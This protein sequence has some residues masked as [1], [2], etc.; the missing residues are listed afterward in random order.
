MVVELYPGEPDATT[1]L[2]FAVPDVGTILEKVKLMG[3]PVV[4]EARQTEWGTR[5]V[6]RDPDG[7]K[8]G[9]YQR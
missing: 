9:L 2:G 7:R 1:R 6:V 8:V 4:Q 3:A 5:A